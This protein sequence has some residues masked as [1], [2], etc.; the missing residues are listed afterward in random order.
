[1]DGALAQVISLASLILR[2][3]RLGMPRLSIS[4][5][6]LRLEDRLMAAKPRP[7]QVAVVRP[8]KVLLHPLKRGQTT[9]MSEALRRS[10][11]RKVTIYLIYA[12][13]KFKLSNHN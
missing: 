11:L 5:Q 2:L 1:M 8:E 6:S 3:F 12:N 4:A 10:R 13:N 9:L 7:L